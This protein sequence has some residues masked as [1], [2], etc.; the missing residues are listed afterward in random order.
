MCCTLMFFRSDVQEKVRNLAGHALA[1]SR[2]KTGVSETR[3][4]DGDLPAENRCSPCP[5][6]PQLD[7][8]DNLEEAMHTADVP[9][10]EQVH[11][12]VDRE[13]HLHCV[14]SALNLFC[15]THAHRC[16]AMPEPLFEA[17]VARALIQPM[18]SIC[19]SDWRI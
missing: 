5:S 10:D 14:R 16:I 3:K 19:C 1:R 4:E 11:C 8:P 12:C 18:Q 13:K 7:M 15:Y 6:V 2:R 9:L 17:S